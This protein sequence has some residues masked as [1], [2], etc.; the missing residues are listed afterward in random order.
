MGRGK[1]KWTEDSIAAMEAEGHG[2][3]VGN[4]YKPW[5]MVSDFSSIGVSTRILGV[6]NSR[7]H[8]F[9]SEIERKVFLL[10]EWDDTVTDIREQYPLNRKHTSLHAQAARIKHP[11]Y[12]GSTISL[13]MTVDFLVTRG[14]IFEAFNVKSSAE[15]DNERTIELLE[16]QRR[17]FDAMD[18]PHSIVTEKEIP[19]QIVEN[20]QRLRDSLPDENDLVCNITS[21]QERQKRVLANLYRHKHPQDSLRHVCGLIDPQLGWPTGTSLRIVFTSMYRKEL[22]TDLTCTDL[23]RLPI[24]LVLQVKPLENRMVA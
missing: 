23:S 13:V 2:K 12:P 3:G 22:S 18:I 17:Y 15:L 16:I 5:I 9:F 20:I 24:N 21:F 8:H 1:T 14:E 6:K 4:K 11:T 19:N 10:Q 7:I